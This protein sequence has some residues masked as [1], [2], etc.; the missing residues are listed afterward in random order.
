MVFEDHMLFFGGHSVER[1]LVPKNAT[2]YEMISKLNARLTEKNIPLHKNTTAA[3]LIQ[4]ADGQI[5]G[6]KAVYDGQTI[7][8]HANKGVIIATGG[9]G[10]S[11]DMRM[12]Y[13]EN[14]NEKI[15]STNSVGSTGDGITLAE[16]I[17]A[18]LVD[19]PY[20]QTY[21][22]CDTQSGSLWYY[23]SVIVTLKKE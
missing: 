9:F 5:T 10:A 17:G 15:L 11:L 14:M 8:Y 12:K 21:P 18:E 22:T 13:N 1:S 20:I 3:E 23:K 6:V 16:K 19:M 7:T 2:G 4:N